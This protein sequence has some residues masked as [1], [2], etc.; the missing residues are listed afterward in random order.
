M[1]SSITTHITNLIGSALY[2]T[3]IVP[4]RCS[5][6]SF[7]SFVY[8]I[9]QRFSLDELIMAKIYLERSWIYLSQFRQARACTRYRLFLAAMTTAHKVEN[10]IPYPSVK[11]WN[12]L[13]GEYGIDPR[14]SPQSELQFLFLVRWQ[15]YVPLATM[16]QA[17]N[18]YTPLYPSPRMLVRWDPMRKN[19]EQWYTARTIGVF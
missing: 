9:S 2:Q 18:E 13:L 11:I 1:A 14:G 5:Q 17:L 8:S 7:H 19:Q 3:E 4:C 6:P 12:W 15:L 10:D 16:Q